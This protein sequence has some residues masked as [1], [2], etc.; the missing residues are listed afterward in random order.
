M[1]PP[2][3]EKLHMIE[4]HRTGHHQGGSCQRLLPRAAESCPGSWV[5]QLSISTKLPRHL[6]SIRLNALIPPQEEEHNRA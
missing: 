2:N 1:S 4:G 6:T 3:S 5:T